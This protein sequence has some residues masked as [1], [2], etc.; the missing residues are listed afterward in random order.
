M[1]PKKIGNFAHYIRNIYCLILVFTLFLGCRDFVEIEAPETELTNR[2]VFNSLATAKSAVTAMYATLHN[3][4]TGYY[5]PLYTGIYGDE[6]KNYSTLSIYQALYNN[7]LDGVLSAPTNIWNTA[8]KIIFMANSII[9]GCENSNGLS[10]TDKRQLIAEAKFM[11]AWQYFYLVNLYGE[12]PLVVNIDYENN[13]SLPKVPQTEIYESIQKD[14][15]EARSS[16][17]P[18]YVSSKNLETTTERVRPNKSAVSALLA[19]VYLFTGKYQLAEDMA[20]EVIS[21]TTLYELQPLDKVFLLNSKEALWQIALS[22]NTTIQQTKEGGSFILIAAPIQSALSADLLKAFEP[23]DQR[24]V[25]WVGK[26]TQTS[27][28]TTFSY[29][30]KY[31][32]RTIAVARELSTP[33]R[34]AELYLI[35]AECNARRD[36]LSGTRA[37]LNA[38]R[39]RA[40][41]PET[42]INNKDQLMDMIIRERRVELFAEYAHRW[43]DL[44]RTGKL[45]EVMTIVAPTKGGIWESYKRFWPISQNEIDKSSNLIQTN[46]Y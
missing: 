14:L 23:N 37:D 29:P 43:L 34:L 44:K 4:N 32:D 36:N 41:L 17:S 31:K 13:L 22:S 24:A 42:I 38:I 28:N 10:E 5:L 15:E 7:K 16:I 2:N 20:T 9:E 12:V 30:F 11:R 25:K 46:G 1:E 19:R 27:T 21:N 40:G 18:Y 33:I 26:F 3:D 35:R 39:K 45:D 6:L 8:Y